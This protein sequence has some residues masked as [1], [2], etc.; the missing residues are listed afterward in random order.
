MRVSFLE[1]DNLQT[2]KILERPSKKYPAFHISMKCYSQRRGSHFLLYYQIAAKVGVR[3]R[4]KNG[5][6][7]ICC[8]WRNPFPA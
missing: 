7:T 1:A 2:G 4:G 5:T 3:P 6:A 8:A